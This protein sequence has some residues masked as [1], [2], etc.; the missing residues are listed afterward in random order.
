MIRYF[1]RRRAMK[2]F[3]PLKYIIVMHILFLII[4]SLLILIFYI[5][6][7]ND[8][9]IAISIFLG[10]LIIIEPFVYIKNQENASIVFENKQIINHINDGTSNFGWAE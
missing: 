9:T 5:I 2:K 6:G 7:F 4:P 1:I 3:I 8:V 10:F